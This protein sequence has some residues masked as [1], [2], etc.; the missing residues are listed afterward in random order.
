MC[1]FCPRVRELPVSVFARACEIAH[2]RG[3]KPHIPINH[4]IAI[5]AMNS[6]GFVRSA[7]APTARKSARMHT[8]ERQ[9]VCHFTLLAPQGGRQNAKRH[10]FASKKV[11]DLSTLRSIEALAESTKR[12]ACP[13]RLHFHDFRESGFSFLAC[14][15]FQESQIPRIPGKRKVRTREERKPTFPEI[16]GNQFG[17]TG[18]AFR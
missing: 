5:L 7:V 13:S 14:A 3:R 18:E 2:T 4:R 8:S 6:Y 9:K 17:C 15:R 16:M 12:F 1:S 11:C 10:T